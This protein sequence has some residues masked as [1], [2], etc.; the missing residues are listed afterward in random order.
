MN[1][2]RPFLVATGIALLAGACA[3]PRLAVPEP[4]PSPGSS[5]QA[6]TGFDQLNG[7]TKQA[8]LGLQR[9]GTPQIPGEGGS[10][11]AGAQGEPMP[12]L[13]GGAVNVNIEGMPV[14]A[15]INEFFGSILGTG[16]QMDPQVS[17]MNDLV[18]LRTSS[19][20]SPQN[21]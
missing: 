3:T 7:T 17:R 6:E 1:N 8:P 13:K 10:L 18:T 20:Q 9:S 16:F 11:V 4:L 2:L 15:F 21:F 14:P 5:S 19:P 12:P